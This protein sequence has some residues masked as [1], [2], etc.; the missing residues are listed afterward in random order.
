MKIPKP[1]ALTLQVE[2]GDDDTAPATSGLGLRVVIPLGA[3]W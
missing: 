3:A 1:W 2:I